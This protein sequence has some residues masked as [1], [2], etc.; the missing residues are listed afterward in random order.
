MKL[1]GFPIHYSPSPSEPSSS[2]GQATSGDRWRLLCVLHHR[3]CTRLSSKRQSDEGGEG[4][5]KK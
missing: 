3:A 5:E 4:V 2:L 1:V